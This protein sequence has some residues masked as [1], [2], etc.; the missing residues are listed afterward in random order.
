MF[1]KQKQ[2]LSKTI[3]FT[4]IVTFAFSFCCFAN[5]DNNK[6]SEMLRE[7]VGLNSRSSESGQPRSPRTPSNYLI[8]RFP[9]ANAVPFL[10][11][12]LLNGPDWK[13]KLGLNKEMARSIA[14]LM[15]G[16]TRD[17]KAFEPLVKMLE[18]GDFP[19]IRMAAAKGLGSLGDKRAVGPLINALENSDNNNVKMET[20]W[21]LN[22]LKSFDAIDPIIKVL[23]NKNEDREVR[24]RCI[25][26]L[27][28]IRDMRT[29]PIL[30]NEAED[31]DYNELGIGFQM[32]NFSYMTGVDLGVQSSG[33]LIKDEKTG[34]YHPALW[35]SK[36][37]P[38]IGK[39]DSVPKIW[40]YWFKNGKKWTQQKFE[41]KYADWKNIKQKRPNEK[42]A[43]IIIRQY[44]AGAG[45]GA[46]P[47]LI[48]KIKQGE[49]EMI[50]VV[51]QVTNT[52]VNMDA[53]STEVLKWWETNKERWTI[54][55]PDEKE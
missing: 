54:P 26:S 48:E 3:I 45:V 32:V 28:W 18:N 1:S 25:D 40:Q 43:I 11:D 31:I 34:V 13:D 24:K 41:G 4:I 22:L 44:I 10:I 53:N 6:Y 30:I 47:L 20:A 17:K 38:E 36:E 35:I 9:D 16:K 46:L 49:T 5:Q 50:P 42:E 52:A 27:I 51:H 7:A 29:L 19:G 14:A 2:I 55:F 8:L 12:V 21:A 33:D 37:L 15:L 23:Q 39:T